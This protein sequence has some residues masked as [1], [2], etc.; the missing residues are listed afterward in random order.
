MHIL[1]KSIEVLVEV[2][3]ARAVRVDAVVESVGRTR[4]DAGIVV[5]TVTRHCRSSAWRV[6]RGPIKEGLAGVVVPIAILVVVVVSCAVFIGA[7]VGWVV[8][9]WVHLCDGVI[10]VGVRQ[11]AG[12]ICVFRRGVGLVSARI[13]IAIL[14]EVV[15]ARAVG[16]LAIV[17]GIGRPWVNAGIGVVAVSRWENAGTHHTLGL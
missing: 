9:T 14:I 2:V 8:R 4:M 12:P 17:E 10:T 11:C 6:N 5:V 3:V 15:I 1:H 16:V 7:V 13:P